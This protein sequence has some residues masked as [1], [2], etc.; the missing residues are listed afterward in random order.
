M[1]DSTY[2]VIIAIIR[3]LFALLAIRFDIRGAKNIPVAGPAV[4]AAN[5]TSYL[6]FTFI[7]LVA[8]D[9][10][11]LVRFLAKDS[12]FHV[13]VI[14]R[15]MSVMGHI[16]VDRSCGAGAYR[17]AARALE[18]GEMVGVFPE[19]TISRAWT[20]KSFKRGAATLAVE[21]QVPLI[22]VITWGGHRLLT[23]D[24]R[25]SLR[26]HIPV[27]VLIG[28]PIHP[29]PG[30]TA[31]E[32]NQTLRRAMVELLDKA[33]SEYPDRPRRLRDNWWMPNHLGGS[34][35]DPAQAAVLDTAKIR[36]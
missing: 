17:H 14:G 23:V 18:R 3:G 5:H 30:E 22:P 10:H 32:V 7:G 11:R 2:R 36:L 26:R 25:Y 8:D 4:I 1:R 16:P 13:P 12:V 20:L 35:P 15:L 24:G 19:A 28:A 29:R 6:D 27:T 9:K 33:Q 21:H 31:E 34:A